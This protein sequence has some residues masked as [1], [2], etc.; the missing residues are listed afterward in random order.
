MAYHDPDHFFIIYLAYVNMSIL[1]NEYFDLIPQLLD[2]GI[3]K[4]VFM[5]HRDQIPDN[6]PEKLKDILTHLFKTENQIDLS[7]ETI[8]PLFQPNGS[9]VPAYHHVYIKHNNKPLIPQQNPEFE[10]TRE[11]EFPKYFSNYRA[12]QLF[13]FSNYRN[14]LFY[15]IG[16]TKTMCI[17]RTK[18]LDEVFPKFFITEDEETFITELNLDIPEPSSYVSDDADFW[19][20]LDEESYQN[21]QNALEA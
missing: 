12:F 21:V 20:H 10:M 11:V 17:W 2:Q 16:E 4:N 3:L 6:F 18:P 8:P 15:L 5:N 14:K 7:F 9:V 19:D 1:D 13:D